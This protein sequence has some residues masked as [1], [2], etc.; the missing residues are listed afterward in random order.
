MQARLFL[1]LALP[2]LVLTGCPKPQEVKKPE[3]R[4]VEKSPSEIAAECG[5][6][7]EENQLSKFAEAEKLCNQALEKDPSQH[8]AHLHLAR[9]YEKQENY[10]KVVSSYEK[11]RQAHP[12]DTNIQLKLADAYLKAKQYKQAVA[13]FEG[14]HKADPNNMDVMNTLVSLYRK[15]QQFA[16]A[17]KLAQEILARDAKNVHVY[18]NL[19]LLY[20]DWGKL[21]QA[22]L[23]STLALQGLKAQDAGIYN[24][25]GMIYLKKKD[26][27]RASANFMA[28][29]KIDKDNQEA[30]LNLGTIAI[31]RGAWKQALEHFETVLKKSPDHLYANRN[32]GVALMGT[33]RMMEAKKV[34]DK[35]LALRPDDPEANFQTGVIYFTDAQFR[36]KQKESEQYFDKFLAHPTAKNLVSYERAKKFIEQAKARLKVISAMSTT[37]E[38]KPR[39][40]PKKKPSKD[41]KLSDIP[42]EAGAKKDGAAPDKNPSSTGT[43]TPAPAGTKPDD[44]AGTP[45][46]PRQT[47]PQP[48]P[49]R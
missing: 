36:S 35:I 22:I 9:L 37:T 28:A 2:G 45:T 47:D 15:D 32:Y 20:Y 5:Q 16:K 8:K 10:G 48:P 38:P 18:R 12:N 31:R 23:V 49:R 44:R 6:I 19:I 11:Y 39:T 40:E 26:E 30:H 17:E 27:T 7:V 42:D 13:M 29:L 33:Q 25:L 43:P 1:L 41:V 46:A 24:N 34:Y 21:N 14:F 4:V 3:V